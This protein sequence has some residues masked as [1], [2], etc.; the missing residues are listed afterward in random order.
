MHKL[1]IV[2]KMYYIHHYFLCT[3]R[4]CCFI[5]KTLSVD[6]V[7]IYILFITHP[8]SSIFTL[9]HVHFFMC[10]TLK[11]LLCC[12]LQWLDNLF[13][14]C[15]LTVFRLFFYYAELSNLPG[16]KKKHNF[17]E[18]VLLQLAQLVLSNPIFIG[19]FC[20]TLSNID[21]SSIKWHF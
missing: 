21:I 6:H 5:M 7:S 9:L 11:A 8:K 14:V 15:Q 3:C 16:S 2:F 10:S 4:E 1:L 17:V 19:Y 18:W 12:R 13:V 20:F